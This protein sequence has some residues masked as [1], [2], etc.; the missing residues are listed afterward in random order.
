MNQTI[1]GR[2]LTKIM[3]NIRC[4]FFGIKIFFK[5]GMSKNNNP[6]FQ[7]RMDGRVKPQNQLDKW[8]QFERYFLWQI[9]AYC[10]ITHCHLS[11]GT[12]CFQPIRERPGINL[13]PYLIFAFQ[14]LPSTEIESDSGYK[15]E[16]TDMTPGN[17]TV[18]II[19]VISSAQAVPF[20]AQ[21]EPIES[22]FPI[23][24]YSPIF[25]AILSTWVFLSIGQT[26]NV[27]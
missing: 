9:S 5:I 11:K 21:I 3:I 25:I 1:T 12:P 4:L 2:K 18:K 10:Y 20:E 6:E 27:G 7:I 19:P 26:K 16:F 14:F 13:K 15:Y 17:Y 8:N 22:L 24:F 23:F